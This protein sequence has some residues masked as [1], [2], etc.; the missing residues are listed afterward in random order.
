MEPKGQ[1]PH[2]QENRKQV[3]HQELQKFD[4]REEYIINREVFRKNITEMK[5]SD[6]KPRKSKRIFYK[7][8]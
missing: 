2:L 5:K 8:Q 4:I 7:E 3:H 1:D 6:E